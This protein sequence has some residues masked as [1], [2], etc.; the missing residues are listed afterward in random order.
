MTT[1]RVNQERCE[2]STHSL[3]PNPSGSKGDLKHRSQ[4]SSKCTA[5]HDTVKHHA[6]QHGIRQARHSSQVLVG[7]LR[8]VPIANAKTVRSRGRRATRELH[9]RED[10]CGHRPTSTPIATEQPGWPRTP[11]TS[12]S[13]PDS[14]QRE[15]ADVLQTQP[16]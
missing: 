11:N 15:R 4:H 9:K 6:P 13:V 12:H 10:R 2:V 1:G 8:P 16:N 3:A 14:S 7:T 5:D